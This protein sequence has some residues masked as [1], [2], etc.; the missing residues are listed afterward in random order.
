MDVCIDSI[1]A[2]L[3]EHG[4]NQL[5]SIGINDVAGVTYFVGENEKITDDCLVTKGGVEYLKIKTF[6]PN[7]VSGKIDIPAISYR[8]ISAIQ[9]ILF[10]ENEKDLEKLNVNEFYALY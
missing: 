5:V 7:K 2:L 8:P 9:N 10:I 6:L 4:A 1:K 3:S